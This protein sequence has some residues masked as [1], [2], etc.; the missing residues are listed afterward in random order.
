MPIRCNLMF[1]NPGETKETLDNTIKLIEEAQPEEWTLSI[2]VPVPGSDMWINPEKY[3][4]IFDKT[5]ARR[6]HYL[7]TN[8]WADSGVGD[9]WTS[10]KGVSNE[11]LK[12]NLEY[13]VKE[14]ERV[15][16]RDSVQDNVQHIHIDKVRIMG[17]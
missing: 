16:P 2:L 12:S 3:G 7:M 4:L 17:N 15:C 14:L 6:N 8:R 11:E 13:F 9:I 1:G 5:M 10:L